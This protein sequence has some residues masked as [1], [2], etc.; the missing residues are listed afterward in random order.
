MRPSDPLFMKLTTDAH[1][2]HMRGRPIRRRPR[3]TRSN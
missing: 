2:E 1:L 3:S